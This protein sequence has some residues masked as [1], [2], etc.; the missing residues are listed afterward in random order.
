VHLPGGCRART[1]VHERGERAL[2]LDVALVPWTGAEVVE[3]HA[4]FGATREDQERDA[5]RKFT[6]ASLP[7]LLTAFFYQ[8]DLDV[9][10]TAWEID[11]STRAVTIGSFL[12]R[13]DAPPPEIWWPTADALIRG[14]TLPEGTHWIRLFVSQLTGDLTVEALL[15]NE[16]WEHVRDG[17]AGAAWPANPDYYSV[18]VFLVVQGGVDVGRAVADLI[19]GAQDS[20][21]R[22]VTRMVERGVPR[23]DAVELV[24]RVPL[25]FGRIAL[26]HLEPA[27]ALPALEEHPIFAEATWIAESGRLTKEEFFMVALRSPELR[28]V[29]ESQVHDAPD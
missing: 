5:W 22:L 29:L 6:L 4:G 19:G 25:A 14:S 21:A 3:S 9:E 26:F 27:L 12:S 18:R 1:A 11:G 15:D 10:R 13:G 24:A 20:D 7:V 28:E 17:L 8:E 16:D 23:E 2:Q